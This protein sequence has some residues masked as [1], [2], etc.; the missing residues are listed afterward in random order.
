MPTTTLEEILRD[1]AAKK[2]DAELGCHHG[3]M[4]LE[5]Q[6]MDK[7]DLAAERERLASEMLAN[8]LRRVW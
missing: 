1:Q 5:N 3:T 4:R 6:A 7:R 2:V 8:S